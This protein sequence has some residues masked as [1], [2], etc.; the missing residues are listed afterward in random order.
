M[1]VCVVLP[2]IPFLRLFYRIVG[3]GRSEGGAYDVRCTM[4]A[5]LNSESYPSIAL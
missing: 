1:R 3:T 5:K 4:F 2:F